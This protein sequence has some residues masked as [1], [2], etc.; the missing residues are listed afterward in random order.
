MA[1]DL[2]NCLL[3]NL[4]LIFSSI[5]KPRLQSLLLAFYFVILFLAKDYIFNA[6]E[7]LFSGK[8]E[9][10]RH[11]PH[12]DLI[13]IQ[14]IFKHGHRSPFRLY[15][16][17][18]NPKELWSEGLGQ[19]TKLG[20]LQL[21]VMGDHLKKRYSHLI[22]SNPNEMEMMSSNASRSMYSAYCF[23]AGMYPPDEEWAFAEIPWQPIPVLYVPE[24]ED[25]HLQSNPNCPKYEEVKRRL[26][27]SEEVLRFVGQYKTFYEFV[28][29]K[30]GSPCSTFEG[31]GDVY[32]TLSVE[33]DSNLTIPEW[34]VQS[35]DELIHQT[36]V[37]YYWHFATKVQHRL[38]GGPIL[39]LIFDRMKSRID[40][41]HKDIKVYGYS[42]H[43]SNVAAIQCALLLYDMKHAPHAA[44]IVFEL[45]RDY[46]DNYSVRFVLFNST[47]PERRL[48]EPFVFKLHGCDEYCPIESF[49]RFIKPIVPHDWRKECA[50]RDDSE[51]DYVPIQYAECVN[52]RKELTSAAAL[53]NHNFILTIGF[54][55]ITSFISVIDNKLFYLNL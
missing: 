25:M 15:K 7:L 33:G 11:Q 38:R 21:Y 13:Q 19:L 6:V 40:G 32:K 22:S 3:R 8:H 34:A 55:L 49:E 26:T 35:W 14:V 39:G 54:V 53:T 31:A 36:D 16:T 48:E 2:C 9:F 24:E 28:H 44:T 20:R 50:E 37:G 45:Y 42:G 43:G 47:H 1:C 10:V 52:P 51:K 17:D 5:A 23:L 46:Q 30:S 4:Y 12:R 27:K 29:N 18:P 41:E